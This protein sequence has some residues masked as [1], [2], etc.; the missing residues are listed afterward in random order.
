MSERHFK[1]DPPPVYDEHY[2]ATQEPERTEC[3]HYGLPVV[4][5]VGCPDCL[6]DDRRADA[7]DQIDR[8][9]RNNLNDDDYADYSAALNLI[10][11]PTPE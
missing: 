4:D 11:G 3:P 10:Y 9:L 1:L 5:G 2:A 8:L 7:Y 6:A